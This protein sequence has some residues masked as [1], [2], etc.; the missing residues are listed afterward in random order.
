M[1]GIRIANSC[2]SSSTV[3]DYKTPPLPKLLIYYYDF[4]VYHFRH[5]TL[6]YYFL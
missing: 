6:F 4:T 2:S 1:F 5:E 3:S